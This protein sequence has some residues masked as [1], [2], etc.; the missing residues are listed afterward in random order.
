MMSK[1]NMSDYID[2]V[3][4]KLDE[5]YDDEIIKDIPIINDSLKRDNGLYRVSIEVNKLQHIV[6]ALYA[7]YGDDDLIIILQ[8]RINQIRHLYDLVDESEIIHVFDDGS[9]VQ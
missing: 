9:F 4:K 8:A 2:E 1:E 5:K 7:K 3:Y 6:N